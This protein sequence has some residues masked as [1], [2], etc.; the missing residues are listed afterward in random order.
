MPF[1]KNIHFP[2]A[3]AGRGARRYQATGSGKLDFSSAVWYNTSVGAGRSPAP[4]GIWRRKGGSVLFKKRKRKPWIVLLIVTAVL[5]VLA[6]LAL[7][8]DLN[9]VS[10][11]VFTPKVEQRHVF[12]VVT[13][14]HATLYG[15][16]QAELTAAIR[17]SGAKAVFLVGDIVDENREYTNAVT[18]LDAIRNMGLEMFMVT[19]NH[20]Y[21][22]MSL[23]AARDFFGEHGVTLL[24]EE[25]LYLGDHILLHG[26][27]DTLFLE[28]SEYKTVEKAL[29]A[30]E[31]ERESFNILLAHRAE[32]TEL[33][34]ST[35]FDL[36]FCGHAHGG[37]VR[38]PYIVNGLFAPAEGWFP[39]FAGGEYQSEGHTVI[40]SRGLM[41]DNMP[42]VFNRPEL[43]IAVIA[44]SGSSN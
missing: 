14:L 24:S 27:D 22:R 6:R 29:A 34:Q 39:K 32:N 5:L 30:L 13:D 2:A 16:G 20:E 25:T 3:P 36:T 42:R 11:T 7:K 19:G 44:P 31:T 41:L 9:V 17:D 10:Y 40:V 26:I 8:D 23:D 33:Y 1:P 43:V 28:H 18:L 15:E 4:P 37:Q 12:A 38:I 35:G 21:S